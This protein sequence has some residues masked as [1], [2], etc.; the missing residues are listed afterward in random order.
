MLCRDGTNN[1]I[2]R[3]LI[4]PAQLVSD[5]FCPARQTLAVTMWLLCVG[6][7]I[8]VLNLSILHVLSNLATFSDAVMAKQFMILER[9]HFTC[10]LTEQPPQ[11]TTSK[12]LLECAAAC[13]C[14]DIDDCM[15]FTFDPSASVKCSYCPAQNITGI[16]FGAPNTR[17]KTYYV[18]WTGHLQN[19]KPKK[20]ISSPG[21]G[22]IGRLILIKGK[23]PVP[24]P[25]QMVID[26]MDKVDK[27]VILRFGRYVNNTGHRYIRL[28]SRVTSQWPDENRR[29]APLGLFPF[30]E[31]V[32]YQIDI[33]T[34]RHGFA[35]Y[36]D[37]VYI[38]TYNVS[39]SR[40]G[41]ID[42]TRHRFQ[43]EI[44]DIFF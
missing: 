13:N 23:T 15:S 43:P 11:F 17:A 10:E 27:S 5:S 29:Y 3:S 30:A 2:S 39:I 33:L 37:G 9:R 19:P 28:S 18:P 31:G 24:V 12:S 34:S 20:D 38:L 41:L 21:M 6:E 32:D 25:Y 4:H 7:Y 16:I 14:Q 22:K 1:F 40:A 8:F 35:V 26:F 42:I 44:T 36:V